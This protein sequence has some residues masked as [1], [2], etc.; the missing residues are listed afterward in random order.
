[1]AAP[2]ARVAAM[3]AALPDE[4]G[5]YRFRDARGRVLYIGRAVRLRRRVRSYWGRSG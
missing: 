2:P 5:V 3:L 1:M 4:P